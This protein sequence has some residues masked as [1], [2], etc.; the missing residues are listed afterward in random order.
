MT[1][2]EEKLEKCILPDL[3][4]SSDNYSEDKRPYAG[5]LD[6]EIQR[7]FNYSANV[8]QSVTI[9]GMGV[10]KTMPY[11]DVWRVDSVI[12]YDGGRMIQWNPCKFNRTPI[13]VLENIINNAPWDA[14]GFHR[15]YTDYEYIIFTA[16]TQVII[17][18][19]T[20]FKF[21]DKYWKVF[22]RACH[23][24][25]ALRD[26]HDYRMGLKSI[27]VTS[28]HIFDKCM[29]NCRLRHYTHFF[30]IWNCLVFPQEF[31]SMLEKGS[32]II[33]KSVIQ[34]LIE[35]KNTP[36]VTESKLHASLK[37]INKHRIKCRRSKSEG[38]VKVPAK[39]V[40][41]IESKRGRI[42]SPNSRR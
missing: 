19:S 23:Y 36:Y 4:N 26:Y 33:P 9:S 25:S 13:E 20:G 17:Y 8:P 5:D 30:R 27:P 1:N 31:R 39:K 22:S 15:A 11:E 37:E 29:T 28:S 40:Q 42:P 10:E 7:K 21:S 18:Y 24:L 41:I 32:H 3:F 16:A 2:F 6:Y 38:F 34:L 12:G 35:G 14:K